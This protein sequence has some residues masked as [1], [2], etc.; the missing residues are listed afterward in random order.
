MG[1]N[2]DVSG[3][4]KVAT[5]GGGLSWTSLSSA[6]KERGHLLRPK[7][8]L[9]RARDPGECVEI[10][11]GIRGFKSFE[12]VKALTIGPMKSPEAGGQLHQLS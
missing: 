9:E 7:R 10:A 5:H 8:V 1:T 12:Q 6:K 11:E 2:E 3:E 4:E